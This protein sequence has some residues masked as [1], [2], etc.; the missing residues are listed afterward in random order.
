MKNMT[1]EEIKNLEKNRAHLKMLV[2]DAQD[3]EDMDFQGDKA[4]ARFS[5]ILNK[6]K[7]FALDPTHKHFNKSTTGTHKQ[8]LGK[9]KSKKSS[10]K[11]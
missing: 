9:K 7:E 3:E 11:K 10:G 2:G 6:N 4:D 1:E 5:S 8:S